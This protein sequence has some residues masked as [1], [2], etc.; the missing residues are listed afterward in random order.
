MTSVLITVSFL[1]L[2]LS[3]GVLF[4]SPPGRVANWTN[5]NILNLTKHDWSEVHIAFGTVFLIG[6][7][8][9]VVFNWRPLVSYFKDRLTRRMSFRREWLMALVICAGVYAATRSGIPP[10]STLLAFSE[11]LKG[12]WEEP[13]QRAPIPHAELLVLSELAEKAGIE[14]EVAMNRLRE[15]GLTGIDSGKVVEELAQQ[16][17]RSAR[18]VYEIMLAEPERSGQGH[19]QGQANR[20]RG[21]GGAGGGMGWKTLS[22]FCAEEGIDVEEGLSRL[23]AK[24][25]RARPEQT[26][27]E[28]ALANGYSRPAD[29]LETLRAK[30]HPGRRE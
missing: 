15:K 28:I 23:D 4:I 10:F 11:R 21:G 25:V 27:R 3:G 6:A 13:A 20:N 2:V 5:W 1:A 16:N 24:G 26:L 9:H 12:S 22:D 19:G 8:F 14:V 29:L 18:E 7:I 30:P 17:G